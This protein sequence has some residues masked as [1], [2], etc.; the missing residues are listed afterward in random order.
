MKQI[1]FCITCKNRFHQIS[2]T[3]PVNLEHNKSHKEKIELV[4]VDFGSTDGLQKWILKNFK[5]ELKEGYLNYFFTD[6]MKNWH[7]S[8]AK[9]TAHYYAKGMYLVN[10][11][12]DNFTGKKG[13]HFVHTQFQKYGDNLLLHQF[14]GIIQNGTYGRIAMHRKFFFKLGGYNEAFEPMGNQD[15]DLIKRLNEFGLKY[16]WL[17]NPEYSN[18]IVNS[19]SESI[20]FCNSTLSWAQM[21]MKNAMLSRSNIASGRLIANSGIFG[22]RSDVLTYKG[23]KLVRAHT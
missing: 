3:L 4:V 21:E 9:N 12:C 18:A 22:Y 17:S 8:I 6:N 14:N 11:D 13:G 15:I 23:N 7:A 19:K 1:S 10:L 5:K 2:Q 16:I 20:K